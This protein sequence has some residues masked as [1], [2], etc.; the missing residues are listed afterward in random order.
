MTGQYYWPLHT[1]PDTAAKSNAL[2][3]IYASHQEKEYKYI[4]DVILNE[5]AGFSFC[6]LALQISKKKTYLEVQTKET[7]SN[8]QLIV[9][10]FVLDPQFPLRLGVDEEREASCLGDDDP[11]LN[12]EVIVRKSL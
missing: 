9:G 1:Q 7:K 12:G 11:V 8:L 10:L 3:K 4:A 6:Q 5:W 2:L